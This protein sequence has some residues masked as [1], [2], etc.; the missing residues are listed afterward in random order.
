MRAAAAHP[1]PVLREATAADAPA[2]ARV[3]TELAAAG[4]RARPAD[5]ASI[6]STYLD[7]PDRLRVTVALLDG[8]VAGFQSLRRA[9]AGNP[10]GTPAGWGLV[11]THIR[12]AAIGRG[13]GRALL[14]PTLAAARHAR[15]LW[16]EAPI[17]AGNAGGLAYYE[18]MGFRTWREAPG[19]ICK[20]R[21][22]D[23]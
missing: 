17:A 18:A 21:P 13:L 12:P 10:Y 6:R 14:A 2:L 9:P 15:L 7:S 5:A 19:L 16:I 4:L 3:Q 23:P 1:G 22:P 8:R 20:R 11:G